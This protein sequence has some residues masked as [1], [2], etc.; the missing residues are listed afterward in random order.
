M[1]KSPIKQALISMRRQPWLTLTTLLVMTLTFLTL[2]A[3][4]AAAYGSEMVLRYLESKAQ[5]EVFFQ[6]K[7]PAG[8]IL[9][10]KQTL[11]A[12]NLTAEVRYVSKEEALSNFMR[13]FQSDPALM[14][15]VYA[16]VL[17]A[18]LEIKAKDLKDL[19]TLAK[20]VEGNPLVESVTFYREVVDRFR[21][22]AKAVRYGGAGLVGV[23]TL[24]SLLVTV[25]ALG[26]AIHL[27]GEEIEIMKLVGASN[28]YVMR[29]FVW[30]GV[31]SGL[32]AAGITSLVWLLS[33]PRLWPA[34]TA[35]FQGLALP[36][37]SPVLLLE[38]VAG[39]LAV[40]FLLGALGSLLA[41]RRYLR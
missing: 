14:E 4:V 41:V 2:T 8:E 27:R 33:L 13:W 17:P 22:F 40:G 3:F 5:I 38:L 1:T 39:E 37:L 25:T 34:L 15:G 19:P 9:K 7:A 23:L 30:Q 16:E 32:F 31:L 24:V 26:M 12:T 11:E 18:S 21:Q 28:G 36:A 20:M 10:M 35:L 6:D 29:P